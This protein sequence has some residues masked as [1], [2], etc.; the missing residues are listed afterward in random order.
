MV[1]YSEP[2]KC[3]Q[4][5]KV[6]DD[7]YRVSLLWRFGGQTWTEEIPTAVP[8]LHLQACS[9]A[10]SIRG[11]KQEQRYACRSDTE[12]LSDAGLGCCTHYFP[13]CKLGVSALGMS[14]M[15]VSEVSQCPLCKLEASAAGIG[16]VGG[17]GG[18]MSYGCSF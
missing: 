11:C 5:A 18:G 9:P 7:A 4:I 3:Q 2:A 15:G 6:F 8:P 16:T 17:S 12:Q 10:G 1:G 14:A 13:L